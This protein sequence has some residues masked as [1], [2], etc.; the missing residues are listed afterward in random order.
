MRVEGLL[1]GQGADL[2]PE[3]RWVL[4][5]LLIGLAFVAILIWGVS[6][7]IRSAQKRAGGPAP[8][9]SPRIPRPKGYV[10]SKSL[11]MPDDRKP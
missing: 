9:P 7:S 3:T 8:K 1:I 6:A 5:L 11:T 4:I 2:T 10:G